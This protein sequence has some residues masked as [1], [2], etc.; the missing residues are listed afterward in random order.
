ME[1]SV[2]QTKDKPRVVVTPTSDDDDDED[3]DDDDDDNT[4][5]DVPSSSSS[6]WV[7]LVVHFFSL[8]VPWLGGCDELEQDDVAS[9]AFTAA[10]TIVPRLF[11]RIIMYAFS[12]T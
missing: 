10:A 3:L 12:M 7:I 5:E 6:V 9:F 2:N 1:H 4:N 8:V 11:R